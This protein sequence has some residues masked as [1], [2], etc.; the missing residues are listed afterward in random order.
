M[1][2]FVILFNVAVPHVIGCVGVYLLL[3]F[4]GTGGGGCADDCLPT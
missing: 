1:H 3:L 2:V 4:D